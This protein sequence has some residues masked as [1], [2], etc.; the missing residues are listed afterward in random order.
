[1]IT[2]PIASPAPVKPAAAAPNIVE[3]NKA[4]WAHLEKYVENKEYAAMR[5][6]VS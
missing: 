3:L 4:S 6:N 5:R 1:M 2:A